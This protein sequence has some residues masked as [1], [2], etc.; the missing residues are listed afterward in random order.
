MGT[1]FVSNCRVNVES[2]EKSASPR[3]YVSSAVFLCFPVHFGRKLAWE[4][5]DTCTIKRVD[6][7]LNASI[8]RPIFN[9][10]MHEQLD[11]LNRRK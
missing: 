1:A 5:M 7:F 8:A 2:S 9:F 4:A 10:D 6:N 11:Q 3:Q